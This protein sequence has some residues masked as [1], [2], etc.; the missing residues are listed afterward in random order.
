MSNL[1]LPYL[2]LRR[3]SLRVEDPQPMRTYPIV[4]DLLNVQD[5]IRVDPNL[6]GSIDDVVAYRRPQETS[7]DPTHA[8]GPIQAMA[9][10]DNYRVSDER[11]YSKTTGAVL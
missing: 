6:L 8:M 7:Y 5:P 2:G 9:S 10:F 11:P 1:D 4:S 3:D